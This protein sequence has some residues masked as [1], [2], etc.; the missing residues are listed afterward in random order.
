MTTISRR[1]TTG[2]IIVARQLH[3]QHLAA[4]KLIYLTF[5]D[6]EKAFDLVPRDVIWWAKRRIGID[7]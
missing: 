5:I 3:V 1:G 6:V 2:A 4:N 7:E